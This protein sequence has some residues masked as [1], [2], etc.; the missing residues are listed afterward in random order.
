MQSIQKIAMN[1]GA[2]LWYTT[3]K[4]YGDKFL[5]NSVER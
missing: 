3:G 2:E 4:G 5:S 1:D